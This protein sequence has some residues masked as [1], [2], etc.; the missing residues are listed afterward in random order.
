[1]TLVCILLGYLERIIPTS[2]VKM[3]DQKRTLFNVI[4]SPSAWLGTFSSATDPYDESIGRTI[5]VLIRFFDRLAI[6]LVC[7]N[8]SHVECLN[9]E[10]SVPQPGAR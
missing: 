1:M 2:V 8:P 6:R 5:S 9:K 7:D 10:A 4:L 3:G